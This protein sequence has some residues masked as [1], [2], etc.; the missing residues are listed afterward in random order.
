VHVLACHSTLYL[1]SG[2]KPGLFGSNQFQRSGR[3]FHAPTVARLP[4]VGPLPLALILPTAL[5]CGDRKS[6]RLSFDLS[7]CQ[8]AEI[9]DHMLGE[10][11]G[12]GVD[13]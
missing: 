8:V 4:S 3:F 5:N 10:I 12:A 9:D 7:F 1:L 13:R 6:G 2:L 11:L